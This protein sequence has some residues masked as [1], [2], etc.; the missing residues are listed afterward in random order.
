MK[1]AGENGSPGTPLTASVVIACY[2]D[3][4]WP[5][6][7]EAVESVLHQSV[8]PDEVVVVVDHN[9][10]LQHRVALQWPSV[11]VL[12]NRYGR[13]ASGSRNTGAFD[14]RSPIV[15][16]L[17][18]DA[19]AEPDWLE[20]LLAG[21]DDPGTVGVGGGVVAS[22]EAGAPRWF[23]PEFGWVIGV[24]YPG[25][26]EQKAKIRNVWSENMAVRAD[27]FR[28]VEGFRLNF[29]KVGSASSPEDTDLCVR[30]AAD[31]GHW[32]YLPQARIAHHIPVDRSTLG[33]FLRRCLSE[34]RGKAS[35]ASFTSTETLTSERAYASRVL[36]NAVVRDLREAVGHRSA[37]ALAQAGAIVVGFGTTAAGYLAQ[38]LRDGI[39]TR[40]RFIASRKQPYVTTRPVPRHAERRTAHLGSEH[41]GGG[42]RPD[43][44]AGG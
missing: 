17:D 40:P 37:T 33:F 44:P 31:G 16:F 28:E 21:F 12:A 32:L 38:R 10:D 29:G 24:S 3:K 15:A 43:R 22:W 20:R 5:Q 36:P 34:G 9:A 41:V 26:P 1:A 14:V 7:R 19:R 2:T 8:Q 4:R 30:M 23:P 42:A 35:L 18:D 6:L 25:L 13:G 11:R 39:P 27:R